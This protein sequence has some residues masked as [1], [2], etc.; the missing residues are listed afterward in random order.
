MIVSSLTLLKDVSFFM[1][2]SLIMQ[3]SKFLDILH[4]LILLWPL[5][6]NPL[7]NSGLMVHFWR[8]SSDFSGSFKL[9][10]ESLELAPVGY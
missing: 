9:G 6:A 3:F 4:S 10:M 2:Y 7:K 8:C 5:L 1:V